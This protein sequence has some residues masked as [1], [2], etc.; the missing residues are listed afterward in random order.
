MK[1]K[2]GVVELEGIV[3]GILPGAKFEVLC[4]DL[5]IRTSLSGKM[6]MNQIKILM[7]DKVRVETS[8]VCFIEGRIIWRLQ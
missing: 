4:G 7:G 5:K 8:D 1:Q 6:R 2:D 3:T